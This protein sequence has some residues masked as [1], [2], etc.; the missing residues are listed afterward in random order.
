MK[1][2]QIHEYGGEYEDKF[3][4]IHSTYLNHE[5]ANSVMEK[6]KS[7]LSDCKICDHC[8]V[9]NDCPDLCGYDDCSDCEN[10][11]CISIRKKYVEEHCDKADIVIDEDEYEKYLICKNKVVSN[12]YDDSDYKIEEEEVIE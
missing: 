2:Y 3:D 11:K 9:Y 6:L 7:R 4:I 8:V 12:Y 10:D 5:K 1:I